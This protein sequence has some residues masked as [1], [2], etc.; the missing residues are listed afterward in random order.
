M[1]RKES[2]VSARIIAGIASVSVAMMWLHEARQHVAEDDAHLASAVEPRRGDEILGAQRQEPAA[3]LARELRPAD[4]RQ[5]HGDH[6]IV[7]ARRPV[8]RQRRGQRQPERDGR[9]RQHELDRRAG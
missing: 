5:D 1:P 2:A 8:Q 9:Q 4:Q 3:H 7:R 6:E